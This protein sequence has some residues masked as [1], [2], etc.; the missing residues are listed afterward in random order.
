MAFK[1]YISNKTYSPPGVCISWSSA[2]RGSG[3]ILLLHLLCG[4]LTTDVVAS[5]VPLSMAMAVV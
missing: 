3:S 2:Y 1:S 4:H 5:L